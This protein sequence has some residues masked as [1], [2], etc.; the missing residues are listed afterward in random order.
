MGIM[1]EEEQDIDNIGVTNPS[2]TDVWVM[3]IIL[4]IVICSISMIAYFIEM[5]V[6]LYKN[7]YN[8]EQKIIFLLLTIIFIGGILGSFV[9][10]W[11]TPIVLVIC[12]T[13]LTIVL[14][15]IKPK[16]III[17]KSNVKE[18]ELW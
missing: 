4:V 8:K 9:C 12:Q 11:I 7:K 6:Y 15:L 13:I 16:T 3:P 14:S 5:W 1:F 2:Y 10:A 18:G 17:T